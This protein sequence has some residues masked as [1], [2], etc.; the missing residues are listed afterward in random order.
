[1]GT[2]LP[3]ARQL[4]QVNYERQNYQFGKCKY[5]KYEYE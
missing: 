2:F 3:E 4:E 1:M 5:E